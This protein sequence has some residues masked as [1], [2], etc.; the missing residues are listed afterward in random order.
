MAVQMTKEGCL[1]AEKYY[2]GK[3]SKCKS[4][5]RAQ[6]KDLKYESDFRESYYTFECQLRGCNTLVYFNKERA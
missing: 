4:E 1:P 5:Y 3:C 2:I 6:Q